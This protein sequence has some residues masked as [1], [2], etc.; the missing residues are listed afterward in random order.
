MNFEQFKYFLDAYGASLSR[1][2]AE[3][4]A[5]AEAFVAD[6]AA[7]TAALGEARRLDAGLD[8][9]ILSRNELGERRVATQVMRRL[10]AQPPQKAVELFEPLLGTLGSLWSRAAVLAAV[11][12]LGVTTG[13]IA[14]EKPVTDN[15]LPDYVQG[16]TDIGPVELADL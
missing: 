7:A 16:P 14:L 10:S 4:R 11:V 15:G 8:R 13:V 12:L 1:W 3:H 5:A 6:S 9:A 2:P